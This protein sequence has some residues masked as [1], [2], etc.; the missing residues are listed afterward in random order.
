[1]AGENHYTTNYISATGS[2]HTVIVQG[3]SNCQVEV[4]DNKIIFSCLTLSFYSSCLHEGG[5]EVQVAVREH[6]G[7]TGGRPTDV[8]V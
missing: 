4:F 6:S 7:G 5:G 1:M 3:Y 8:S 2:C